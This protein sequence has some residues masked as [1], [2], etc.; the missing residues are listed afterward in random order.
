MKK[1]FVSLVLLLSAPLFASQVYIWT[2][3]HGKKHFSDTPPAESVEVRQETFELE[4]VDAGYPHTDADSY[5]HIQESW[6]D[7]KKREKAEKAELEKRRAEYMKGPCMQARKDLSKLQGRVAFYDD[8]GN[9]IRVSET[10]RQQKVA[11]LNADINRYC[12]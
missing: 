1:V 7:K 4:N 8:D 6:A 11:E 5:K 3:E 10:D 9:E 12:N 2:D